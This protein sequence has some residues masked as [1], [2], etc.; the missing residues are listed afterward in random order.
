MMNKVSL[1]M[2]VV[3]VWLSAACSRTTEPEFSPAQAH[4]TWNSPSE[5]S[6]GSMPLGNG[7]LGANVWVEPSGDLVLL[8]SKNDAFDGF[9]RLLKPGKVR[10]QTDPP[11][12]SEQFEQTLELE[13]GTIRV[14][15]GDTKLN[16]WADA[17]NPVIQ[18]DYEASQPLHV[19]VLQQGWRHAP[20]MLDRQEQGEVERHSAYGNFPENQ[21][22]LADV[23]LP[24]KPGQ[25]A[26]M[27]HNTE[28]IWEQN[29]IHTDLGFLADQSE[30]PLLNRG[31]G[32]LVRGSGLTAA[33]DTVMQSS[34]AQRSGHIQMFM[35]TTL[36]DSPESW[37]EQAE[38]MAEAVSP[39]TRNRY[40]AHR[41]WWRDFWNRSYISISSETDSLAAKRMSDAWAIQRY[42]SASAGRG[43]LPI[44]FNGSQF[45]VDHVF[46]YDYRRWG[47]PFWNQNTR[48]IYWPMLASGD[49]EMMLPFFDFYVNTLPLREAATR[50][51]FGHDGAFFP[52]T[53][54][55]W[56]NYASANYGFD[57]GDLPLGI[58]ENMYIRRHWEGAIEV[59]GMMLDYY[60]HVLDEEFLHESL[61]PLAKAVFAAYDQHWGRDENGLVRY[62]PAQALETWWESVNPTPPIAGIRFLLP[63]L[64]DLPVEESLKQTWRRQLAEQ[65]PVPLYTENGQ[66]RILPAAKFD[67]L[68]NVENPDM[69][70]VFPFRLYTQAAGEQA[71]RIGEHTFNNRR[72][73]ENIGWQQH[74]VQAA[75][76][77]L[78]E[79]A[80][81][82]V[83][84]RVQSNA[85]GYRFPGFYGPFYDW[86]PDQTHISNFMMGVQ[87]MALQAEDDRIFVLP[88]WPK[89]WDLTFKLHAPRQTTVRGVVRNGELVELV[90]DPPERRADVVLPEQFAR[91]GAAAGLGAGAGRP[92][93]AAG[94]GAGASRPG[95]A[96]GTHANAGQGSQATERPSLHDNADEVM[97]Y[98][99]QRYRQLAFGDAPL[100]ARTHIEPIAEP[101]A[102][103]LFVAPGGND[104]TG[105]GSPANPFASLQR[106]RDVFRAMET[107]RGARVITLAP[108]EYQV[109]ETLLLDHRDAAQANAPL[110]L[111]AQEP[112]RSILYGG[113]R[114]TAFE[115]VTDE[116]ILQR[117]P[118]ASRGK[119]WQTSLP[120]QGINDFGELRIRGF[121]QPPP[122]PT[123]EL[124]FN[125]EPMT[126]ARWPNEGFVQ[127]RSLEDPGSLEENR[128]AVLGYSDARHERWLQAED[129]WLFG[130]FHFLWADATLPLGR[131]QPNNRIMVTAEPYDYRGRAMSDHQGIIYYVFNLLEEIDQP[132]EWYLNRENGMLYIYPPADPNEAE[133]EMGVFSGPFV[134]LDG[135]A[136]V[137]M[138]GLVFDLGRD[139][140]LLVE[141]SDH[142]LLA[143]CTVR[144]M[145]GSGVLVHGGQHNT[146]YGCDIHTLGRRGAEIYGGDRQTLTPGGHLVENNRIFSFGRIDRTYVPAVQLEGVGNRVAFNE[147]FDAPS[148]VMRVEGNDHIVEFNHIHSAVTISDDQG[149]IDMWGNP[150]YRGNEFRFNLF[151]EIRKTGDEP[152]VHGQA[153]IRFDDAISGQMVYGNIFSRSSSGNFGAVQIH[154]GRDNVLF[155][156]IF[157]DNPH[158][159][160]GSHGTWNHHWTK[161]KDGSFEE[162]HQTPLY[163]QRYPELDRMFEEGGLNF[164]WRNLFYT[165]E[166]NIPGSGLS[167]QNNDISGNLVFERFGSA[168]FVNA[169]HGDFRLTA[170]SPAMHETALMPVPVEHT[171]IYRH[172]LRPASQ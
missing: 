60:D 132:G 123:M 120:E 46:D 103:E 16:I 125:G 4:V 163:R 115:P 12:T 66:T 47:G 124:F 86:M 14:Q 141:Q 87:A 110:I 97:R 64:L 20:R 167:E 147:F 166:R 30:D 26:W 128:P 118:A 77:G 100:R 143:G 75:L 116:A 107:P 61:V 154:A 134:H 69:Y 92:G 73:T 36:A 52:E 58:T 108:G 71:R 114:L 50:H 164:V 5:N 37:L 111:R 51:Y 105:D 150:V 152:A 81:R 157:A 72:I 122:A 1:V 70:A 13:T 148:S 88:A 24:S 39:S 136:H 11:L 99:E 49:F 3:I 146:L 84:E 159:I 126:L 149:A 129:P 29:L 102:H 43:E 6:R 17:N 2:W 7:D 80:Q 82:L 25:I 96:A 9:N 170:H 133:V 165:T 117:L 15:S 140:G 28:S 104:Q 76:L 18:I 119:V 59:V 22:V 89:D 121:A 34:D 27:H 74:P 10:I 171:G 151:H 53:M 168:G 63:R 62:D 41:Q 95:A 145:A 142:I 42:Q 33:S 98:I 83:A 139:D 85:A 106:A 65:P 130:F 156:N 79:Q 144:R 158:G 67:V 38:A 19:T 55:L 54:N 138:E 45:T 56:G 161:V 153:A 91:E 31:F 23:I 32:V 68:R 162:Y 101:P 40:N 137:R 155:N 90:V 35:L 57:R 44:K 135:T 94:L 169:A 8:L 21:R 113:K 172:W 160:T 48:L 78:T 112:G 131:I 127:A 93:D 109:S